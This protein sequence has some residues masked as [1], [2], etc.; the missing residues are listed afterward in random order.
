[1]HVCRPV[2]PPSSPLGSHQSVLRLWH[3]RQDQNPPTC[4]LATRVRAP[5]CSAGLRPTLAACLMAD[6]ASQAPGADGASQA[7]VADGASQAPGADGASQ[8]PGACTL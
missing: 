1:L 7:P 8:A 3:G 2:L 5:A 6:G 4:A